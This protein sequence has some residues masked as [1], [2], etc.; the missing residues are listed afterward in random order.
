LWHYVRRDIENHG[1]QLVLLCVI[2]LL[3]FRP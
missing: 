3:C 2:L 1:V